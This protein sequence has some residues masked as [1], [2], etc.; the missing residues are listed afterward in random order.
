MWVSSRGGTAG[1]PPTP[2]QLQR[3]RRRISPPENEFPAAVGLAAV[4]GRTDDVAVG[5]TQ[6]D[7][8][9]TG[10]RFR[11]AIRLRQVRAELAGGGLHMLVTSHVRPGL[12]VPLQNRLLLGVEY[13]DGRRISNLQDLRMQGPAAA[14]DGTEL[15]LAQQGGGG[16]DRSVDQ[17]YWL[18]PLPPDGPVTVV[19]AWPGFGLPESRT[20]LDGGAILAAASRSTVLWP[21]QP[22]SEPQQP[23]PAPR[24]SS[25]WFAQPPD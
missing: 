4:L 13:P 12:D 25:G 8:Y 18:A 17:D 3:W 22:P 15:V 20:V 5:I 23:P 11:L 9:S 21:P 19:L 16:D 1:Q 24:P 7:A 10:F 2:E 14:G 6:L